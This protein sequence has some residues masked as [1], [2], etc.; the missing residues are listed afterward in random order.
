MAK[1]V[2]DSDADS[3]PVSSLFWRSVLNADEPRPTSSSS[4][5]PALSAGLGFR[6]GAGDHH[7]KS[8]DGNDVTKPQHREGGGE[9]DDAAHF[10]KRPITPVKQ[11]DYPYPEN[12]GG[13][14]DVQYGPPQQQ[15]QQQQELPSRHHPLLLPTGRATV[16][17]CA[18]T[19]AAAGGARRPIQQYPAEIWE[20]HKAHL[21]H[22]YIQQGKSLKQIQQ[23]MA[24]RGFNA[25][26]AQQRFIYVSTATSA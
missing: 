13:S 5:S 9:E 17:P 15:Q 16:L 1:S 6:A 26:L 11:E 23:I 7:V 25:R 10:A 8:D 18:T 22:L 21:H 12:A 14:Y 19:A 3:K 24:Q 4:S 2:S 20:T